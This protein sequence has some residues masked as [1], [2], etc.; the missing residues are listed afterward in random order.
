MGRIAKTVAKF[1]H[2]TMGQTNQL[3]TVNGTEK[4]MGRRT[5]PDPR[6][7]CTVGG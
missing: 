6:R 2:L 4:L 1:R 3:I 5:R 7:L